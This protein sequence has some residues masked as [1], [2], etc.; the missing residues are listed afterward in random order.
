MKCRRKKRMA[1]C[2]H[3]SFRTKFK[4]FHVVFHLEITWPT[5]AFQLV[6]AP[7]SLQHPPWPNVPTTSKGH[8]DRMWQN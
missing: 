1:P 8:K 5:L 7:T 2:G 6:S 4:L 3:H